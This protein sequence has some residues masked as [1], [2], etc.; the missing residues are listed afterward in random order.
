MLEELSKIND[1]G[2]SRRQYLH[3]NQPKMA[4]YAVFENIDGMAQRGYALGFIA[5]FLRQRDQSVGVNFTELCELVNSGID[6]DTPFGLVSTMVSEPTG[7]DRD[8]YRWRSTSLTTMWHELS[9]AA[10]NSAR[11]E[12][13]YDLPWK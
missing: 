2:I 10:S 4:F 3:R 8:D 7:I 1:C 9:V 11:G 5:E 13:V 6:L 12:R